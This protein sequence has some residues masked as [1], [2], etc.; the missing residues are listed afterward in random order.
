[1]AALRTTAGVVAVD[2][3]TG[4]NITHAA[5]LSTASST[6]VGI[7][8][9]WIRRDSAGAQTVMT[10][11]SAPGPRI[12]IDFT[13]ADKLHNTL[14]DTAIS[15]A[16][17]GNYTNTHSNSADWKHVLMSWD[18]SASIAHCYVNDVSDPFTGA[19]DTG[20]SIPW[21]LGTWLLNVTNLAEFYLNDDVYMDLSVEANRRKFISSN[22]K[23]VSLGS[24]GSLP[25]GSSPLIYFH[26][27]DGESAANFATN[28]GTGGN[29]SIT[30]TLSTA[31][32]SPS[33]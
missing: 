24:D 1:M 31:S 21:T 4:S 27:D 33:D 29:F 25:T 15:A 30:G 2:G 11:D 9:F 12:L 13:A 18:V 19:F 28:R 17:D 20:D 32:T 14:G 8:S 5:A 22:G 6:D 7:L 10:V 3:A 26:L 23:P 16:V